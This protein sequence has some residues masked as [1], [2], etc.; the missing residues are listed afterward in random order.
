MERKAIED[1][2]TALT[3]GWAH[4]KQS[5]VDKL[6]ASLT[7]PLQMCSEPMRQSI[8]R[9]LFRLNE[10]QLAPCRCAR[11]MNI[12]RSQDITE[13]PEGSCRETWGAVAGS[14]RLERGCHQELVVQVSAPSKARRMECSRRLIEELRRN[15]QRSLLSLTESHP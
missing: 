11:T 6:C 4:V 1:L 13:I 7:S 10:T 9:D 2:R 3:S 8:S 12:Q 14:R 15:P 5:P